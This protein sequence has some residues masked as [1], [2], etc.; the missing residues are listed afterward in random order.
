MPDPLDGFAS[1]TFTSGGET[2]SLLRAGSGPAVIVLSEIPGITPAVT[3]FGERVAARGF[4]AVLP[5]LFGEDGR[6]VSPGYAA[7]SFARACIA[8]EFTVLA[9][10]RT[11]PIVG[12]LRALANEEHARCGGRG[13]G[14]VGMC[15]TGGFALGMMV[16]DAVA[17]PVLSQPSL[18]IGI[19]RRRRRDLGLSEQDL[20]R[21]KARAAAGA[22][23]L[24]L[25]FSGDRLSPPERFAELRRALGE[26]FIGIEIDSSSGNP[27]G[28]RSGAHSV[29][30][31]HLDDRPGTPTRAALEEVLNFLDR[32]LAREE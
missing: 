11:S 26:A 27:Y 15:F 30:T 6:A 22:C 4:T 8:K 16:E 17:A 25:R 21:V 1:D 19:S 13:V 12:W 23:V 2:R 9:L 31:E 29:L 7:S 18:P 5:H 24:G 14:A 3:A 32:Q 10:G 28:H 20:E